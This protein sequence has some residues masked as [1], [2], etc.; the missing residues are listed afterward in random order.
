[1]GHRGV[2]CVGSMTE[3]ILAVAGNRRSAIEPLERLSAECSSV[4][5]TQFGVY[6]DELLAKLFYLEGERD[7]AGDRLTAARRGRSVSRMAVTPLE[8]QRLAIVS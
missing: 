6:A 4:G 3:A 1:M 7:L 2:D 8:A 5:S